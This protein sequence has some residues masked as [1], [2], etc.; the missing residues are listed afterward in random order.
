MW[1]RIGGIASSAEHDD[2]HAHPGDD[3]ERQPPAAQASPAQ[4]RSGT[5]STDATENAPITAPIA[6]PRRAGGTTSAM[7]D[8]EIDV[9]G[10]PNA[11]AITRASTSEGS[12]CA[13]APDAGADDQAEQRDAQ[14]LAPVEAIEE[15]RADDA[16]DRRRRRVAA[17][18]Q[19][20]VRRR[21][22]ER[23]REVG[24]ER[25]HHHEVEDVDELDRADQEDDQALGGD[26]GR[27]RARRRAHGAQ[28]FRLRSRRARNSSN[29][30]QRR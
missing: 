8:S 28:P 5:P 15:A 25:H 11:P 1:P 30:A 29:V 12:P 13:S 19:A 17:R 7:I 21:D 27:R 14:R 16:R 26:D 9:A 6:R 4:S 10:P 20:E 22:A 2:D 23:P 18:D 3:E 24:P